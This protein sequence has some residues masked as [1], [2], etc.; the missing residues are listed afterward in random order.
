MKSM[1]TIVDGEYSQATV[2]HDG[3]LYAAVAGHHPNFNLIVQR[4]EANDK[5]ESVVALFDIETTVRT[6]FQ[7]LTPRVTVRDG[8]VFLD[9]DVQDGPIVKQILRFI[10]EGHTDDL[11]AVVNFM[12]KV[13]TNPDENCRKQLFRW[14]ENNEFTIAQDG[15]VVAYK[16]CNIASDG[17]LTSTR[18]APESE[19]VTVD[20]ELVT[21]YVPQVAGAL[22]EMPRSVVDHNPDRTCSVGLHVANFRYANSFTGGYADT[23]HVVEV[24]VNPRDFVSVTTDSNSEKIRCC[25]YLVVGPLKEAYTAPV[26]TKTQDKVYRD[27]RDNHLN[28]DRYPKGHPK[29]GQFKPKA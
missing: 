28:Q 26:L 29:A 8:Q 15:D 3:N 14:L 10:D 19:R 25:R 11:E 17:T 1:L 20:G 2:Y 22:V 6:E 5:D 4:L 18:P 24:R 9:G 16:G 7:R 23:E 27:T 13:E 21:G 12:E